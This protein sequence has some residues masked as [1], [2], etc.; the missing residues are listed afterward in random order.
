MEKERENET[1]RRSANSVVL[2]SPTIFDSVT[3]LTGG[4]RIQ[5]A[6]IVT[7]LHLLVVVQYGVAAD[8]YRNKIYTAVFL[9][10]ITPAIAAKI[11]AFCIQVL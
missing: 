1:K 7:K 9:V 4:E 10:H 3:E 8:C 5:G 2:S 6:V 11:M